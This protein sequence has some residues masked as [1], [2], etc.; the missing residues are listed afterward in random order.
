MSLKA[1]SSKDAASL[2]KDLMEIGGWSL[3][4]L[5]ELAGL[6]VSQAVHRVHPPSAGKNILVVCGPGNNGKSTSRGD[7]LV[8][9]RH[10]AQYG[11]EPSVYY[12]KEGKNELYQRLKTQLDNLSVP[13]ITDFP[14]AIKSADLLVDAIFGFSFGGPLRDPFPTI[15][16][17][18]EA[19][20]VPVLSVDAPSSW[21]IEGGPPKEG[22]GSKFMPEYLISLTAPKP[23]VKYY[24]G[25]HFLGGRFLTKSITEKYGLDLPNYPGIDQIVEVGVDAE[26]RL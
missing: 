3:D 26:G 8:A 18:I 17:Q 21:D 5:M 14:V 11:Y 4:Q 13:F 20:S 22:P 19:A 23:C 6:S 7:G 25:R 10:L 2:D 24:Q 16:S 1:I 9:A 15:I 12:P